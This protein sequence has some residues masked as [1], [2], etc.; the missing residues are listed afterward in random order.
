MYFKKQ[1]EDRGRNGNERDILLARQAKYDGNDVQA[2]WGGGGGASM[3]ENETK[4]VVR[5]SEIE[6]EG[7][8]GYGLKKRLERRTRREQGYNGV[9]TY[10]GRNKRFWSV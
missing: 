6:Y 8:P 5:R 1:T 10:I 2:R 3:V 9:P 4:H 7:G